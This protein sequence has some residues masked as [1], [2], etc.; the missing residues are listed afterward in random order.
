[1][2][3]EEAEAT[4]TPTGITMEVATMGE[5]VAEATTMTGTMRRTSRTTL[6]APLEV[7]DGETTS[8]PL[9]TRGPMHGAIQ[10]TM[11]E[12]HGAMTNPKLNLQLIKKPAQDGET[13]QL[14]ISSRTMSLSHHGV[15]STMDLPRKQKLKLVG[16]QMPMMEVAG[17]HLTTTMTTLPRILDLVAE[18]QV[19]ASEAEA[20]VEA[21]EIMM[22]DQDLQVGMPASNVDK[23]A[24][25]QENVPT[26]TPDRKEVEAE[27]VP[28]HA[29]SANRKVTYP[30]TVL[31]LTPD[32]TEAEVVEESS[33]EE[34][35]ETHLEEVHPGIASNVMRLVTLQ[36]NVPM[37]AMEMDRVSHT[38]DREWMMEV[39]REEV[40]TMEMQE[41]QVELPGEETSQVVMHGVR[42]TLM[43][44]VDGITRQAI[45]QVE[46]ISG[47]QVAKIRI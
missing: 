25:S 24:T 13:L 42:V 36:E 41:V 2:A 22:E 12:V 26:Q 33:E 17:E 38:R 34:A 15:T 20:E 14:L 27:E 39:L 5:A 44:T 8:H 4:M 3:S 45:M 19:Q 18:I 40:E 21:E 7:V 9:P 1:M 31:I 28:E 16:E 23:K 30:E 43:L 10:T 46:V 32:Q 47:L 29:S 35:E 11:Q 37:Q 6:A